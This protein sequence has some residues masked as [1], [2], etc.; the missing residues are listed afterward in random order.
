MDKLGFRISKGVT[1]LAK[2]VAKGIGATVVDTTPV[3]T[4]LARSNWRATLNAP[5]SGVIPPYSPGNH[6]GI[7]ESANAGGAKAQQKQ[8]IERFDASKHRS[9]FI[10]NNVRY[11]GSLD[12]G[13]SAQNPAGMIALGISTGR[14]ILQAKAGKVL[15]RR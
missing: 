13:S 8:A 14:A 10:T 2:D 7:S 4:G 5:A 11:I 15:D 12:G 3:D 9:I 1:A 6:L